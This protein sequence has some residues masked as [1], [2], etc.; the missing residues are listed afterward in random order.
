MAW[1]FELP[2]HRIKVEG[3]SQMSAPGREGVEI[4]PFLD[5]IYPFFEIRVSELLIRMKDNRLLPDLS[6]AHE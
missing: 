6:K 3:A 5:Q 2:G 4:S 1:A